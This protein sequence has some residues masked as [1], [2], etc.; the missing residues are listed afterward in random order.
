MSE[1]L[2]WSDIERLNA[3]VFAARMKREGNPL[4]DPGAF[5][6]KESKL[7]DQ[8]IAECQRRRWYFVHSRTDRKT[9]QAKGVPDFIIAAPARCK[10]WGEITYWVE[11]KRK[12]SKLSPEQTVTKHVLTALGHRYA[13]VYSYEEFLAVING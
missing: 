13:C 5:E 11:C 8:I 12:G 6:G 9:T 3:K 4:P 2:T 7:H 1:R 10:A